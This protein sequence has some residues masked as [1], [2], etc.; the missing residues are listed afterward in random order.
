MFVHRFYEMILTRSE[1]KFSDL[2]TRVHALT[3]ADKTTQL[4]LKLHPQPR[5]WRC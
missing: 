5:P 4:K 2:F 1:L 3:S